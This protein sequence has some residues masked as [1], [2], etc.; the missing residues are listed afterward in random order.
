MHFHIS[1]FVSFF[2]FFS[3]CGLTGQPEMRFF[4]GHA[5]SCG[6]GGGGA[7][8][9]PPEGPLSLPEPDLSDRTPTAI[10]NKKRVFKYGIEYMY[11]QYIYIYICYPPR[12]YPR[13][14]LENRKISGKPG[15]FG[16]S[17]KDFG[18]RI[19]L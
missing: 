5:L 18:N 4:A 12:M 13:F 9:D 10:R 15:F 17:V 2:L 8:R 7:W 19:Y 1:L 11:I 16:R 6:G 3:G 14:V